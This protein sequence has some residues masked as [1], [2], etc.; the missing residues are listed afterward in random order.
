MQQQIQKLATADFDGFYPEVIISYATG[1]RPASDVTGA[2]PGM[3][4]AAAVIEALFK[5]EIPCFSGVMTPAGMNCKEYFLRLDHA[6][7]RVLVVLLS[8][9]FFQS[10]ACLKEVH[11]AIKKNL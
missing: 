2:G 5:S 3:F 7:A 9:A 11:D 4:I 1:R 6:K 8:K 10:I